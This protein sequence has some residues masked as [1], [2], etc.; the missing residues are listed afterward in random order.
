MKCPHCGAE[1]SLRQE[2]CQKCGKKAV[3]DFDM[4]A[5]S[6]HDDAAVRR[7]GKIENGLKWGVLALLFIGSI[8]FGV[9]STWD[10][11]IGYDGSATPVFDRAGAMGLAVPKMEEPYKDPR[12]APPLPIPKDTT[13]GY[14]TGVVK[15]R[16]IGRAHV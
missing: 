11:E 2:H 10:R 6:V 4:L 5:S 12:L 1:M 16:Q 15:D 8:L 14:R 3:V 7:G 13:F 9:N